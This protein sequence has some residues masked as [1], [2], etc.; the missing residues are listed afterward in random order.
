M[1]KDQI[2]RESDFRLAV[3]VFKNLFQKGILTLDQFEK[4]KQMLI[5][6]FNPP[7]GGLKDVLSLS[8]L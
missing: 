3:A 7:Y 4:A 1:T 6:R 5:A 2:Y 8:S